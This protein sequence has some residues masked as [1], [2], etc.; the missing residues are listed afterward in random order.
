MRPADVLQPRVEFLGDCDELVA[1]TLAA[2]SGRLRLAL[3][4]FDA[5]LRAAKL[6]LRGGNELDGNVA[7]DVVVGGTGVGVVGQG[8]F[9]ASSARATE[10]RAAA[11]AAPSSRAR[12]S[13]ACVARSSSRSSASRC[14]RTRARALARPRAPPSRPRG[15]VRGRVE[16]RA[17]PHGPHLFHAPSRGLV[18]APRGA[19]RSRGARTRRSPGATEAWRTREA[20]AREAPRRSR[21]CRGRCCVPGVGDR[22]T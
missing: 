13:S 20:W 8:G 9:L 17:P 16:L 3:G 14:T 18:R 19:R 5:L 7:R 2:S 21:S 22:D 12:S 6:L 4:V 10:A 11:F 1:D 15:V